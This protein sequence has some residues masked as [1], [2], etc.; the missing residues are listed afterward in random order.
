MQTRRQ[1]S[2]ILGL[3]HN[4]P[5]PIAGDATKSRVVLSQEKSSPVRTTG[6]AERAIA[7]DSSKA[8]YYRA[9]AGG[10]ALPNGR[11]LPTA[12]EW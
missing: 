7:T 5:I 6:F 9:V 11:R 2:V 3:E 10:G 4:A 12:V 8:S 1:S